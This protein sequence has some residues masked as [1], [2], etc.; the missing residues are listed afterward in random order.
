LELDLSR[1]DWSSICSSSNER[2]DLEMTSDGISWLFEK[3]TDKAEDT[4]PAALKMK[5]AAQR[6]AFFQTT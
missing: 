2:I 4:C 3:Q 1:T 6:A 5:K